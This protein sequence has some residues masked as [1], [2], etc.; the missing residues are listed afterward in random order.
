MQIKEIVEKIKLFLTD[1]ADKEV[2]LTDVKTKD[3]VILSFD[4]DL[5]TGIEIFVT[6]EAG[7]TPAPDGEYVLEDGTKLVVAEGMIE[8]IVEAEEPVEEPTEEIPVEEVA[9][10]EAETET[11][12]EPEGPSIT[13]L[14]D[15][16]AKL[17]E[18][19]IK[20]KEILAELAESFNKKNFEEEVKMSSID[21]QIEA[22]LKKTDRP[23]GKANSGLENIFYNMYNKKL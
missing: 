13:D 7:R 14:V 18:E 1:E 20:I 23:L 17:E 8:E 3:G 10:M 4:G 21:E 2:V 9:E 11:E 12:K 19:N 22:S 5:A 16:I 6:D 15:K